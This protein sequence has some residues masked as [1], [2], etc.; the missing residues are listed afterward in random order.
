MTTPTGV[1]MC[2]AGTDETKVSLP[3]RQAERTGR[4]LS[5][6]I[7]FDRAQPPRTARNRLLVRL[8]AFIAALG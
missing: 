7:C 1:R 3:H 4:P 2:L 6:D 8:S 5:A